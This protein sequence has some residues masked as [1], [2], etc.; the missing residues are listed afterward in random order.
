MA[1]LDLCP[2]SREALIDLP[3]AR[4]DR[5]GE[6]EPQMERAVGQH[7]EHPS[8]SHLFSAD[9]PCTGDMTPGEVCAAQRLDLLAEGGPASRRD[10]AAPCLAAEGQER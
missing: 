5:L 4:C 2:A 3:L 6:Q 7:G 10:R 8:C 1:P 9:A